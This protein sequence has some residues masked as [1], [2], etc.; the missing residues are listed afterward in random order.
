MALF[1]FGESRDV[2]YINELKNSTL[3]IYIYGHAAFTNWIVTKLKKFGVQISGFV[4]DDK[5]FDGGEKVY[6]KS[7]FVTSGEKYF[8]VVGVERFNNVNPL[9]LQA[10]FKNCQDVYQFSE[11]CPFVETITKEFYET[12]SD[13]ID[14][15]Y[16]A[17]YDDF[18]KKSYEAYLRAKIEED[19]SKLNGYVIKPGFFFQ[20][21]FWK[22]TD[23]EILVDGGAFDGD[24]ISDFV[25]FTPF[26]TGGGMIY[27]FEPDAK[28]FAKLKLNPAYQKFQDRIKIVNAGLGSKNHLAKFDSNGNM[29]SKISEDGTNSVQIFSLDEFLAGAPVTIIKMDI[30]GAEMDALRGAAETIKKYLPMLFITIEHKA[31]DHY[32]IFEFINSV[33]DEYTFFFRNHSEYLAV[34]SVLYAIPKNRLTR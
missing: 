33:S 27:A 11:L 13:K 14:T 19:V 10:S 3:P 26:L 24:T 12:H 17:L 9:E 8:L 30:E 21:E 6:K 23:S 2:R 15:V 34:D 29:T 28:N 25:E 31:A 18:S 16:N 32:E 4:V 22:F 1:K 20:S 7:A 5:Y